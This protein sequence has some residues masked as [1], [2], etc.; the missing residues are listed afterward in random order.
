MTSAY[1]TPMDKLTE[2]VRAMAT[3]Q[4]AWPSMRQ[5]QPALQRRPPQGHAGAGSVA[6]QRFRTVQAGHPEPPR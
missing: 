1:P 5:I 6:H 3:E 4:G 2:Q